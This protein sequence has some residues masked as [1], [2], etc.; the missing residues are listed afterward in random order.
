MGLV[1]AFEVCAEAKKDF[2]ENILSF[3]PENAKQGKRKQI[4]ELLNDYSGMDFQVIK[5]LLYASRRGKLEH[6]LDKLQILYDEYLQ[7]T[8]SQQRTFG[9]GK[10]EI[11]QRHISILYEE[12]DKF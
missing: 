2:I 7:D 1:D 9:E 5:L 4:S 10:A 12:L 3:V 6:Y 11:A 8:D